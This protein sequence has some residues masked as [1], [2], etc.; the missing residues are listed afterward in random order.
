MS[1]TTSSGAPQLQ[2]QISGRVIGPDSIDFDEARRIWNAEFDRR[3]AMIVRCHSADDVAATVRYAVAEDIEIAVRGGAHSMSGQSVVDDGLVIDLSEMRSVAVDPEAKRAR[4]G[5]G[6]LLSD[7]DAAAQARGLAT[8]TGLV[9]HT[10]VGGLTLGGGMGWLTRRFGLT[11]DNLVLA[12]I[13]T[14]DGVIRHVSQDDE[15]DLFWAIRGGGGNFGVVTEF[16]FRLHDVNPTVQLGMLFWT[17][18][19]G[20]DMLRM[21][22]DV[23]AG[24]P[25]DV[26]VVLGAMN[27]P[28]EPFVPEHLQLQPGFVM[29]VVGFSGAE[30]H[31]RVLEEIR[32]RLRPTF[33]FATPMPYAG[34]QQMLDKAV[35]WGFYCYDKSCYVEDLTD[36]VIDVLTEHM[37][38]KVSP[39]SVVLFYRLDGAYSQVPDDATAFSGGRSPRYGVFMIAVCPAPDMLPPERGW[40]HGLASALRPHTIGAGVYVN[41][42]SEFDDDLLQASY[43][44]DKYARLAAT[45]AQYDP[46]NVFHRNANIKPDR[47]A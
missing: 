1:Q 40:I 30:S 12:Q 28:P 9:S 26:N 41:G 13:V 11:I 14:A 44:A 45:K 43:G 3:P 15:P 31:A 39:L 32:N 8:P 34:L 47:G 20:P 16:E 7:L 33:E 37:P 36:G 5:G 10:G 24:L 17:L 2:D 46:G 35:D 18:D 19:Q 21:A 29:I 4:A 42:A 27:A 38:K 6:A 25:E 22:R 23:V